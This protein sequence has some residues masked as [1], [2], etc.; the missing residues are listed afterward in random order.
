MNRAGPRRRGTGS[1]P[2]ARKT[3]NRLETTNSS[4]FQFH[5]LFS[6]FRFPAPAALRSFGR[7]SYR[8]CVVSASRGFGPA[9][10]F[11]CG[12]SAPRGSS[13]SSFRPCAPSMFSIR[14]PLWNTIPVEPFAR[15]P[16]RHAR[17]PAAAERA[18]AGARVPRLPRRH[19]H[20]LRARAGHLPPGPPRARPARRIGRPRRR[21]A[22]R[23]RHR[24]RRRPAPRHR[25]LSV[26]ARPRGDRRRCTTRRSRGRSSPAARSPNGS[27]GRSART[28]RPASSRSFAASS[29]SALQGLISGSLDLDKIE[30]LRRDVAH[31]RRRACGRSTP[32]GCS[33]RSPCSPTPRPGGGASGSS[34]RGWP[35]SSRCLFAKY[36]MYRNVYWHHAVRSATVMYK[37]LVADALDAGSID[38][39]ALAGFTD[40]AL[41]A[42]LERD[43]P[44]GLL[45]A[46]RTRRLYKRS[47][48][49]PA[50]HLTG[51]E[52]E[53]IAEDR[54]LVARV[55][56]ALEREL[57]PR[58]GR[59]CC[60]TTPPRPRC[61]ASTCRCSVATAPRAARRPR[62]DGYHRPA[63][64]VGGALSLSAMVARVHRHPRRDSR[65]SPA[66]DS[67]GGRWPR[68]GRW[69]TRASSSLVGSRRQRAVPRSDASNAS[70]EPTPFSPAP[71]FGEL[72][73]DAP[74]ERRVLRLP[75]LLQRHRRQFQRVQQVAR[76]TARRPRRRSPTRSCGRRRRSSSAVRFH[77]RPRRRAPPARRWR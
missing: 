58:T 25:A 67:C 8:P 51:D 45:T 72:A 3:A 7:A 66:A 38:T 53:W 69:W 65:R 29:D 35:P 5:S 30:Y 41:L 13:V 9:S 26:L 40:E 77:R 17:L 21:A 24:A 64:A 23:C 20:A 16:D 73:G 11:R 71:R 31:V 42:Q 43:H 50:A 68:C 75:L 33:T 28:H 19:A 48:E 47:F 27:P 15:E 14:D 44:S 59:R 63:E 12:V 6:H 61:W 52:C 55:E 57:R 36:Q 62:L 70:V 22:R 37:R 34:R 39:A 54:A 10:L 74:V 32:T 60:S 49:C 1:G 18:P 56:A 46:L 76:G 4:A 2:A